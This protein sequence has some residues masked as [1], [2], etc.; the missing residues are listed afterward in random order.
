MTACKVQRS[1][2]R[3]RKASFS[4]FQI[5][6]YEGVERLFVFDRNRILVADL[7]AGFTAKALLGIH[8]NSLAILKF[9]NLDRAN[10]HAF[11][12]TDTLIGVNFDSVTH[13][14]LRI[15]L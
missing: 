8:R 9:V 6:D 4:A 11:A 3:Q 10:I 1:E 14:N 13:G 5:N 7:D 12:V 15:C 2:M